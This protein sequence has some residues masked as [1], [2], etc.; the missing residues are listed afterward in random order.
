MFKIEAAVRCGF[1]TKACTEE[2]CKWNVDFVKKLQPAPI[3]SINFFTENAVNKFRAKRKS[4]VAFPGTSKGS[5]LE[6]QQQ[7][8]KELASS[9]KQPIVM[10]TFSDY[11]EK[12]IPQFQPPS[13]AALPPSLRDLFSA[14]NKKSDGHEFDK[15]VEATINGLTISASTVEYI[16]NITRKQSKSPIWHEMRTGRITASIAHEVLHTNMERPSTSLILRICKE[17]EMK[18][19]KVPSL[20]WGIDNE[21]VALKEY[22]IILSTE[23]TQYEVKDC[24]L[25]L[26][27]E[28]PFIGASPDG[29]FSCICHSAKFLIEVKCPYSFKDTLNI[30]EALRQRDFFLSEQKTLKKSHKYYAQIQLQLFVCEMEQCELVVWTPKWLYH[31]AV[32]KDSSFITMMLD[33][34]KRFFA[35]AIVPE[36]LTRELEQGL[37]EPRDNSKDPLYCFCNSKHNDRETWI[38][39]VAVDCKRQWFH[40][41][42]VRIKRLPKG[43][44]YCPD[45]RKT[46][47]V[48]T[49]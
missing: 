29:I 39:C 34:L 32:E 24:G 42:C 13:R 6:E 46:K 31:V 3:C 28:F 38:G 21:K 20:R 26:C 27:R 16:C 33:V 11:C 41:Q 12:F 45:C 17:S 9:Q 36:L 25:R 4:L 14:E 30:D 1:T 7:F 37:K 15:L 48:K 47:K 5:C 44:W 23:H 18:A 35:T 22:D 10:H 43:K 40:P 49:N 19:S 8:L 2:A